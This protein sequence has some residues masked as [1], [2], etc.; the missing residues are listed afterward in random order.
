MAKF[1][2]LEMRERV[3]NLLS[4]KSKYLDLR[5]LSRQLAKRDYSRELDPKEYIDKERLLR[6]VHD[7]S[8]L[9]DFMSRYNDAN[10]DVV[11]LA[12]MK[13]LIEAAKPSE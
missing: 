3:E 9:K 12:E 5:A 11:S 8:A 7:G 1:A 10:L 6:D 2:P 4:S 13:S